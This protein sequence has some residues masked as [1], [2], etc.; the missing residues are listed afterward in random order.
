MSA[1]IDDH[2][3]AVKSNQAESAAGYVAQEADE[4]SHANVRCFLWER[5]RLWSAFCLRPII[6]RRARE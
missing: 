1:L 3:L 6:L 4:N 5:I 2:W